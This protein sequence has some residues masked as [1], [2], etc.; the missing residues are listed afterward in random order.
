MVR[1]RGLGRALASVRG[2]DMGQDEHHV[3]VRR[4]CRPIASAHRQQVHVDVTKDVPQVTEDA[5][6]MDED[7]PERTANVDAA[8]VEGIAIDG[9]EGSPADHAE[10][11]L[12]GSCD[13]LVL[14]SFA[15]HVAHSIWS[16]EVF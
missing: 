16:G 4:Q 14:T 8:D 12:G 2:R 6:H 15:D 3:D 9:A 1:T 13:P 11:F 10:G 7:I 5:P